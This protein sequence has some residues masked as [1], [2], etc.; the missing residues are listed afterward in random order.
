[1]GLYAESLRLPSLEETLEAASALGISWVELSTGGQAA[2]PFVDV[3]RLLASAEARA[4]LMSTL[5]RYGM[6]L[7]ALNAGA[8]PL[9]P[10]LGPDHVELTRK[11]FRLAGLLGVDR[12]VT[13]SGV[14]GDADGSRVPNWICY[15]WPPEMLD[16]VRE[17]WERAIALWTDLAAN[18]K[19]QGVTRLCFELHPFNLVYNVPTLFQLR[20]AVGPMVGVNLDPAHLVWQ[21]MDVP[22]CVRALGGAI[23]HVHAKDVAIHRENVALVGLLDNRPD[24]SYRERPWTFCV[25]GLGQDAAW[26]RAFVAALKEVGYDDVASIEHGDPRLPGVAGLERTVAFLKTVL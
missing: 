8:F 22:A 6:R 7:S 12:I 25:P 1:L 2:S 20:E 13:Q 11:T 21:G 16:I 10:R 24:V 15:P 23:Y 17:Q 4:A 19:A 5:D 26:W 18:A 9:H 3:D 14:P